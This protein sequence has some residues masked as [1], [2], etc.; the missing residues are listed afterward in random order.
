MQPNI[1]EPN[2]FLPQAPAENILSLRDPD[3]WKCQLWMYNK[4]H[5]VMSIRV[6]SDED[7]LF[8]SFIA[9]LFISCPVGWLGANFCIA[10]VEDLLAFVN[11]ARVARLTYHLYQVKT[12][13]QQVQIV[14]AQSFSVSPDPDRIR[15]AP[16][17]AE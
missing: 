11:D 16:S 10:P 5:S 12:L 7:S 9:V 8:V 4:S 15:P 14:A 6:S 17:K 1:L 13:W 2:G 3:A